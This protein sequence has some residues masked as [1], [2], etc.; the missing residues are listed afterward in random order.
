MAQIRGKPIYAITDVDLIPLSSQD[1]ADR[2]I[3]HAQLQ[4]KK[5]A[6]G[7][8]EEGEEPAVLSDYESDDSVS[9][10]E[11]KNVSERAAQ[12]TEEEGKPVPKGKHGRQTS[13]AQ[14]VIAKKGQYGRFA[15]RWFSRRGWSAAGRRNQGMSDEDAE[16]VGSP[17]APL[18]Q[19]EAKSQSRA[20]IASDEAK[21]ADLETPPSKMEEALSQSSVE[22]VTMAILPKILR[23]TKIFFGSKSFFFSYDFDLSR[24]LM[25]QA[26]ATSASL[27]LFKSYDPLVSNIRTIIPI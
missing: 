21:E 5:R 20:E 13:I 1:Q 25:T 19:E 26:P 24:R 10:E 3:S 17:S 22:T 23:T 27:P 9:D 11:A 8:N 2:A 6:K 7:T 4:I 14:D 18:T 12:L 16:P 15:D